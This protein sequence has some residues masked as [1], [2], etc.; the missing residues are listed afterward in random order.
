MHAIVH[1]IN[2]SLGNT[3]ATVVHAEIPPD[4]TS[5]RRSRSRELVAD[6]NSGQVQ[7][8]VILGGNP[9]YTAP[10]DLEFA[11]ALEEGP[12]RAPPLPL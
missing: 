6:M 11:A 12:V 8:L 3:G 5:I 1:A 9:V 10:V 7:L 4:A 2:Q